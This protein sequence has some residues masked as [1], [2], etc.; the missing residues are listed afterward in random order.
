VDWI[1]ARP[2]T[3]HQTR[4]RT[5]EPRPRTAISE[6]IQP[7]ID[8]PT[9]GASRRSL[10]TEEL[11]IGQRDVV[12]LGVPLRSLGAGKPG[13]HGASPGAASLPRSRK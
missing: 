3:L 4:D 11:Q 10:D 5:R 7:P 2:T 1:F 6:A 8:E 12:D 13:M 9:T